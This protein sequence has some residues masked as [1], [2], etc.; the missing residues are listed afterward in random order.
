[1]ML[2]SAAVAAL[3]LAHLLRA[4][5]QAALFPA[6]ARPRTFHLAVG[7]SLAYVVNAVVPFRIGEILRALYVSTRAGRSLGLVLATV[8]FERLTDLLATVA[9]LA[10]LPHL[11]AS[12]AAPSLGALAAMSAVAA[13]VALAAILLRVSRFAR[14]LLW[15]AAS[16]FNEQIRRC[17]VGAAWTFSQLLTFSAT[18]NPTYWLLTVPMWATYLASYALIGRATGLGVGAVSV[19]LLGTPLTALY[20]ASALAGMLLPLAC[21]AALAILLVGLLTDGSG[22]RRS[23]RLAL[24]VGLPDAQTA[25]GPQ[26][27]TR[28]QDYDAMLRA[29]FT[30][31]RTAAASFGVDGLDG[32]VV[33]RV[34]PGGSDALTAVVAADGAFV[35]RKFAVGAG[36]SKL[37][38]QADWLR[39]HDLELPLASV[40]A[41]R[42]GEL[43]YR[44]DMPYLAS[45]HDLYEMVHVMPFEQSRRLLQEVVDRV[46]RWHQAH[47]TGPCDPQALDDY[48]ERKVIANAAAVLDFARLQLPEHY[49][50]ND[51]RHVLSDW[52]RLLD[53]AWVKAQIRDRSTSAIH[54][55]LTIENIIVCPERAPGWY[56]IDPNPTN[57]F[58]SPLIDWAKLTQS[59]NLGYEALSRG[60][61]AQVRDGAIRLMFNRSRAYAEL[62]DELDRLLGGRLSP[63]AR[64][65]VAFHEVVNYL[66]LIPYKIRNQPAQAM[67]FFA[68]ASVLLRRYPAGRRG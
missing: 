17:A 18:R 64:R 12:R 50:I 29:H 60:P 9:I 8:V 40:I 7:L 6:G 57:L 42:Q 5:R 28:D 56:L 27:F 43:T 2:L 62:H 58:D 65:E 32:A 37:T 16:L 13:A 67:T 61:P 45:G 68:C 33:Q 54:G 38:E 31:R 25:M 19:G 30:E 63:D 3:V 26:A 46:D 15:R 10:I 34:L 11:V 55:D 23:L 21:A 1:M 47:A 52:S 49:A 66:R 44:Y 14:G 39:R 36:A 59:L 22:I 53:R 51:E 48:V 35:I 41:E 4:V 20:G 24:H